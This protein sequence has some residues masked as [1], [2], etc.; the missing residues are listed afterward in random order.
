MGAHIIVWQSNC[1][2]VAAFIVC[3]AM[4][5]MHMCVWNRVSNLISCFL[6]SKS[7]S[8]KLEGYHVEISLVVANEGHWDEA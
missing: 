6:F 4:L 7:S 5:V 2:F 1:F 3:L 8:L